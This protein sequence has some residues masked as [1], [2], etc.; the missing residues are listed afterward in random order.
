MRHAVIQL[1]IFVSKNTRNTIRARLTVNSS[2]RS[3]S[4]PINSPDLGPQITIIVTKNGLCEPLPDYFL[5]I[6][7]HIANGVVIDMTLVCD[8]LYLRQRRFSG[9][10]ILTTCY[11]KR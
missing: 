7:F 11:A 8:A 2:G 4:V 6:L 3:S 9:D 10:R 5:L 1:L